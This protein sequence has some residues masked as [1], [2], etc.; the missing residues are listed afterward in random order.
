M[1]TIP[2]K[3]HSKAFLASARFPLFSSASVIRGMSQRRR[4]PARYPG[5]LKSTGSWRASLPCHISQEPHLAD[6]LQLS[7]QQRIVPVGYGKCHL[8][9]K[10]R[11]QLLKHSLVLPPCSSIC[12]R[13]EQ[14]PKDFLVH[15]FFSNI[16]TMLLFIH[17]CFHNYHL[18][19]LIAQILHKEMEIPLSI[20]L[21]Y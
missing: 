17:C 3:S 13:Q 6:G 5:L 1:A 11:K 10:R 7:G 20:H 16:V 15:S 18:K 2:S 8:G 19:Y 14:L 21:C 12:L 4:M 9:D